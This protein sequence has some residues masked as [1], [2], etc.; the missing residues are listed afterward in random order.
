MFIHVNMMASS[1]VEYETV[2]GGDFVDIEDGSNIDTTRPIFSLL[3]NNSKHFGSFYGIFTKILYVNCHD[4]EVDHIVNFIRSNPQLREI[5]VFH[6]HIIPSYEEMNRLRDAIVDHKH[7][8]MC[9]IENTAEDV[10]REIYRALMQ[11]KC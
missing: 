4:T 3:L 10:R 5:H 6:K 9:F 7:L 1:T 8:T 2:H 11:S